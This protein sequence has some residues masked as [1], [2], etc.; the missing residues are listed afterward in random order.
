MAVEIDVGR[1]LC[2]LEALAR[3]G[4]RGF[5]LGDGDWPLRGIV[6]QVQPGVVRAYQ[7]W[8]PHAGHALNVVP[9]GFLSP[10]GALLRCHSHGAVF[11]KEGGLCI[12]G[13]CRGKRLLPVPVEIQGNWVLLAPGVDPLALREEIE[14]GNGER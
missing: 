3:D 2:T 1:A 9:H 13:P 8:C 7:N 11:E 14:N 6:V 5:T 4:C 10:D 12:S